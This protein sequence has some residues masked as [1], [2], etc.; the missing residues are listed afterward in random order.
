MNAFEIGRESGS[1]GQEPAVDRL[2]LPVTEKFAIPL[3]SRILDAVPDHREG[4]TCMPLPL[5]CTRA[6]ADQ[7]SI[8]ESPAKCH[9]RHESSAVAD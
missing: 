3:S 4:P 1:M 7:Q 6:K 9:A 5:V 8:H 2:Q